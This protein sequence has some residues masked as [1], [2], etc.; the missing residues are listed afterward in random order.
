MHKLKPI[1]TCLRH[2]SPHTFRKNIGLSTFTC[3]IVGHVPKL[4]RPFSNYCTAWLVL[5]DY[6]YNMLKILQ[7]INHISKIVVRA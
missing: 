2:F 5:I 6:S 3:T 4:F 7:A 1:L